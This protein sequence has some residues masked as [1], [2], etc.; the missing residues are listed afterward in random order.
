MS[1]ILFLRITSSLF[2]T[3]MLLSRKCYVPKFVLN[4]L[5]LQYMVVNWN[6]FLL[7]NFLSDLFSIFWYFELNNWE[8]RIDQFVFCKLRENNI[9][10]SHHHHNHRHVYWFVIDQGG[11]EDVIGKWW[12]KVNIGLSNIRY[13]F[14][15]FLSEGRTIWKLRKE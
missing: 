2:L 12:L 1:D 9:S 4:D 15:D 5:N 11:I 14:Y 7:L 6:A 10:S 3:P 13:K 8:I